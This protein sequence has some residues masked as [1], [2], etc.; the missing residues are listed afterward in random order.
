MPLFARRLQKALFFSFPTAPF[1][2]PARIS[3][4]CPKDSDGTK[5]R[6][7][8]RLSS[9]SLRRNSLPR[10]HSNWSVAIADP[11]IRLK[12]ALR[13]Y[14]AA[15]GGLIGVKP[16]NSKLGSDWSKWNS[17]HR[18]TASTGS[19]KREFSDRLRHS[20]YRVNIIPPGK[21]FVNSRFA[22]ILI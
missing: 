17:Q 13:L 16:F 9:V 22:P 20:L 18:F 10:Y 19:L 7:K 11:L 12:Q 14:A 2:S 8:D 15:R 6:P 5:N 1:L 4:C 21:A 3:P